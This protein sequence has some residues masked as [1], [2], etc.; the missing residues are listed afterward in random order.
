MWGLCRSKESKM[1]EIILENTNKKAIVDDD[2]FTLSQYKW[3]MS[4]AG[5]ARGT[6]SHKR[7]YMHRIILKSNLKNGLVSDHINGNRLDNQKNNLRVCSPKQNTINS[8]KQIG[9]VSKYKGVRYDTSMKRRKR[10]MAC[11]KHN[12]KSVTIGRFY[13]EEGAADAY[14]QKAK[15]I[16]GGYAKLNDV[17]K[18]DWEREREIAKTILHRYGPKEIICIGCKRRFIVPNYRKDTA[19]YCSKKCKDNSYLNKKQGTKNDIK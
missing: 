12:T 2:N 3:Q 8:R 17:S 19:K 4:P 15:E 13:T 6:I 14:N 9:C 7:V 18:E 1:K 11:F 10:W 5:Y 16:W